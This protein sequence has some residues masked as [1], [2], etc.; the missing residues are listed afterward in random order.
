MNKAAGADPRSRA[1]D[2]SPKAFFGPIRAHCTREAAW[3]ELGAPSRS[4]NKTDWSPKKD[5]WLSLG[6]VID[7]DEQDRAV[8][9][10]VSAGGEVS[11]MFEGRSLL[12]LTLSQAATLLR[13]SDIGVGLSADGVF[14]PLLGLSCYFPHPEEYEGAPCRDVTL[15]F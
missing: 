13:S 4:V 2:I 12:A 5:Q 1:W 10:S 6:A 9:V 11:P 3:R 15:E 8:S 7:F 14:S